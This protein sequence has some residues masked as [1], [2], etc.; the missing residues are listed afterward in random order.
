M[1]R[2][3]H[4]SAIFPQLHRSG[5]VAQAAQRDRHSIGRIIWSGSLFEFEHELEHFL[6][7]FFVC[8]ALTRG[9]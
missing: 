3:W 5:V 7:L 4:H 2:V 9:G 8:S 6:D 1:G